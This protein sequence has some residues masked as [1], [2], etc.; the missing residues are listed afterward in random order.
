MRQW[1]ATT[2]PARERCCHGRLPSG[3]AAVPGGFVHRRRDADRAAHGLG[4]CVDP[5]VPVGSWGLISTGE[6]CPPA[7]F[8]PTIAEGATSSGPF[9]YVLKE[10]CRRQAICRSVRQ[11]EGAVLYSDGLTTVGGRDPPRGVGQGSRVLWM[12]GNGVGRLQR[13]MDGRSPS[14][15]RINIATIERPASS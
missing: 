9:L 14:H 11:L 13:D 15:A 4:L 12:R 7:H 10:D 1:N 6:R 8:C 3:A 5:R 2:C